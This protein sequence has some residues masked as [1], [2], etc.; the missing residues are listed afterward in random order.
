MVLNKTTKEKN[1]H[2]DLAKEWAS[3]ASRLTSAWVAL[4][5]TPSCTRPSSLWRVAKCC[6][7]CVISRSP[8][9]HRAFVLSESCEFQ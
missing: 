7:I 8:H 3:G 2:G 9:P 6:G 1:N 4:R 5:A